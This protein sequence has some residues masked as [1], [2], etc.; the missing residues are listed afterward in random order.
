LCISEYNVSPLLWLILP[1]SDQ[2]L[3]IY[4]FST[5]ISTSTRLGSG[6]NGYVYSSA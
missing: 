5:T 2:Y 6:T 4:N 1:E 3:G